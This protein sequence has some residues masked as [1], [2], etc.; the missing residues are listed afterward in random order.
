M[1]RLGAVLLFVGCIPALAVAQLSSQ[2]VLTSADPAPGFSG[3]L[4]YRSFFAPSIN[5]N[6][7]LLVSGF[8]PVSAPNS[9]IWRG[10]PGNIQLVAKAGDPVPGAPGLTFEST[11]FHGMINDNGEVAFFGVFTGASFP[12][13]QGVIMGTPGNLQ[14]LARPPLPAAGQPAG[15]N[16]SQMFSVGSFSNAGVMYQAV[17]SGTPNTSAT[18]A[19]G[20]TVPHGTILQINQPAPGISGAFLNFRQI[21]NYTNSGRLALHSTTTVSG[22]G[23]G[24]TGIWQG[25]PA[26]LTLAARTG[27]SAPGVSG[28]TFS[29]LNVP[30]SSHDGNSMVFSGVMSGAGI[31]AFNSSALWVGAP[32]S[33]TMVAR[34][35]NQA[36][37]FAA[38]ITYDTLVT[39]VNLRHS[40][41]GLALD[42]FVSGVGISSANNEALWISQ[43]STM[44]LAVRES[45]QMPGGPNGVL[46]G[47]FNTANNMSMN[48]DGYLAFQSSLTGTGVNSTN[49]DSIWV[50]GPNG[51]LLFIARTGDTINAGSLGMRTISALSIG[52]AGLSD[53]DLLAWKADFTDGSS[54]IYVTA[55][56]EPS[57]VVLSLV[58]IG[59]MAGYGYRRYRVRRQLVDCDVTVEEG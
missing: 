28:A 27:T 58:S 44:N 8:P 50:G 49:N 53:G 15:V 5:A 56:P 14:T 13:N 9:A 18:F 11:Y 34:Q 4:T 39:S 10:T 12:N 1:V 23:A 54:A 25:L 48:S 26:S 35:G 45:Q 30:W 33:L 21:I 42:G 29:S 2:L 6:G 55:I 46:F 22:G 57:T 43:G 3:G 24:P 41:V 52:P 17:L 19:G 51:E 16:Y 7:Q 20:G 32:G 31:N 47:S 36:A 37:G 59:L 38:G 40:N